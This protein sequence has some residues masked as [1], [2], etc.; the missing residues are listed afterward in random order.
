MHSIRDYHCLLSSCFENLQALRD[1]SRRRLPADRNFEEEQMPCTAITD[2]NNVN[3]GKCQHTQP[4]C[5]SSTLSETTLNLPTP[6]TTDIQ[7]QIPVALRSV[8]R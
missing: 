2:T 3:I 5:G 8:D 7:K 4:P 1:S 6:N